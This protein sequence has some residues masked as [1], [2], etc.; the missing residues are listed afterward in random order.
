VKRRL[1]S[2][3]GPPSDVDAERKAVQRL[4]GSTISIERI[5]RLGVR[6]GATATKRMVSG[7]TDRS[8]PRVVR[9]SETVAVCAVAIEA[10]R[11]R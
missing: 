2:D 6:H 11:A 3:G 4:L 8:H 7:T 1:L 10:A 5:E 9:R